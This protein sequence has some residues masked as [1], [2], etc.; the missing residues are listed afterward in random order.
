MNSKTSATLLIVLLV[1]VGLVLGGVFWTANPTPRPSQNNPLTENAP[2]E[3]KT[4]VGDARHSQGPENARVTLVVFTDFQCPFCNQA[5]Q[6]IHELTQQYPNDLRVIYRFY[7][8][9]QQSYEATL[10]AEFAQTQGKFLQLQNLFYEN[11]RNL[12]RE[13]ILELA[14]QVGLNRASVEQAIKEEKYKN[15]IANDIADATTLGIRGTPTIYLNNHLLNLS[16]I[17]DLQ[18]AV[19][20]QLK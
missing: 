5:H 13:K 18:E 7:P 15:L 3:E 9:H 11:A 2:A 4:V 8:L 1:I 14:E 6:V 12:S 17:Q 16:R 19:S 10:A 20:Q